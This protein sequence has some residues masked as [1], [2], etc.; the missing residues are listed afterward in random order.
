MARKLSPAKSKALLTGIESPLDNPLRRV[1][2]N[3]RTLVSLAADGYLSAA[4][5]GGYV[6]TDTGFTT[7][8]GIES[9]RQAALDATLAEVRAE[10]EQREGGE[11]QAVVE[12]AA[13]APV[14][15]PVKGS[16]TRVLKG[17]GLE[18]SVKSGGFFG[19]HSDGFR[20]D[21]PGRGEG[22]GTSV[23]V[24]WYYRA[25]NQ[26]AFQRAFSDDKGARIAAPEGHADT[27]GKAKAAL[28]A[29][30]FGVLLIEGRDGAA[31]RVVD[32][33]ILDWHREGERRRADADAIAE[34]LVPQGELFE[35]VW[36]EFPTHA[37]RSKHGDRAWAVAL[38]RSAVVAGYRE[39]GRGESVITLEDVPPGGILAKWQRL[40]VA[41]VKP[42]AEVA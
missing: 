37:T 8:T 12:V 33:T 20:Q 10:R 1:T 32:Q 30:G 18:Q 13:P 2:G 42:V 25:Q 34:A 39:Q 15:E 31:L 38:V 26:A 19:V 9:D 7:A 11:Q 16:I 23:T 14:R 17:A 40:M 27:V 3:L 28:E 29:A 4:G 35:G 24:S 36:E 5:D 21:A 6:L 22:G 41:V